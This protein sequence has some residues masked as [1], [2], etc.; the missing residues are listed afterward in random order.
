MGTYHVPPAHSFPANE[1]CH[2]EGRGGEAGAGA[3]AGGGGGGGGGGGYAT[4]PRRGATS[5][6]GATS[7]AGGG[8]S[9]TRFA[10]MALLRNQAWL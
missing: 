1:S 7:S 5:A 4:V 6:G 3:S 2:R 10:L 9:G 8:C